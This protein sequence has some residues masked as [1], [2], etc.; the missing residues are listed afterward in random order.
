MNQELELVS[1][2]LVLDGNE[3]ALGVLK[4]FC[5]ENHLVGLRASSARSARE[6][7]KSNIDLGAILISE[8]AVSGGV[9]SLELSRQIHKD[10]P[11]L[12]IFLRR[13]NASNL[14]GIPEQY[15]GIFSG[16]YCLSNLEALK[17]MVQDRLFDTFYPTLLVR[18]IMGIAESCLKNCFRG[19]EIHSEPP[20]LV[21]DK[22]MDEF[23]S[24]IAL[25]SKWCR[26]Y[27]MLQIS[28]GN[29]ADYIN[30]QKTGNI[31]VCIDDHNI[32]DSIGNLTNEIWGGIK[33]EF[34]IY[35]NE[36]EG[37][38]N[39]TQ[40]PI[41]I[42]PDKRYISFGTSKPQL[43]YRFQITDQDGLLKPLEITQK[44]IFNLDWSPEQFVQSN[45]AVEELIDSGE[46]EF[47]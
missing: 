36:L 17:N 32:N 6:V 2:V 37:N 16:A 11:D 21:S 41:I 34:I 1:K 9:Y 44:M 33:R 45:Q 15:Q 43:C 31:E 22:I 35:G 39:R 26:G 30:A 29:L 42:N 40:V 20:F 14:D 18:G 24:L 13:Y 7:L 8:E 47:F 19:V 10:R 12:P 5:K 28:Q 46:L 23:N 25:E 27:M 4:V 3:T 38:T